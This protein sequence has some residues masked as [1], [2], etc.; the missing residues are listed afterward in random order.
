VIVA[1]ARSEGYSN[2][3]RGDSTNV[4]LME[5]HMNAFL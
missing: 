4:P 2:T 1:T 3:A 5:F